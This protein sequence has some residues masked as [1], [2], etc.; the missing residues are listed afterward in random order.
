VHTVGFSRTATD[1]VRGVP[2]PASRA[3]LSRA[4]APGRECRGWR[5][6][7]R[8]E[9]CG[10][11]RSDLLPGWRLVDRRISGSSWA[12]GGWRRVA[13]PAA[14]GEAW[15]HGMRIAVPRAERPAVAGAYGR[16]CRIRALA[17]LPGRVTPMYLRT[18]FVY[19]G[20][21]YVLHGCRESWLR[22]SDSSP[23]ARTWET[24][25][26]AS[27]GNGGAIC[28][29]RH[30]AWHGQQQPNHGDIAIKPGSQRL[31]TRGLR[32]CCSGVLFTH[33]T[34]TFTLARW[35]DTRNPPTQNTVRGRLVPR[36]TG[37]SEQTWS[38]HR[39]SEV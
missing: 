37:T 38:K 10:G 39:N 6:P 30:A 33:F 25:R 17:G 23:G 28:A 8:Q 9:G 32:V 12:Q 36:G 18:A 7:V 1:R 29:A 14:L 4:L 11:L 21:P 35:Q 16:P 19:P 26:A 20:A 5:R 15:R 24:G 27:P 13:R 34:S 3:A 2:I 22:G 31:R